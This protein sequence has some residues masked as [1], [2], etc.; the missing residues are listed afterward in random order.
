MGVIN[1]WVLSDFRK[2]FSRVKA[3]E[4][5]VVLV[6]G[7]M[8][9]VDVL[10]VTSVVRSPNLNPQTYEHLIHF[11]HSKAWAISDIQS[12]WANAVSV[13]APLI[14]VNDCI[15][16]IIDGVKQVKEAFYSPGTKKMPQ[17]SETQSKPRM[18][19]GQLWGIVSVLTGSCHLG[20]PLASAVPLSAELQDGLAATADWEGS[21]KNTNSH[22]FQLIQ[23]AARITDLMKKAAYV[24][25][26]T[27]FFT[28][29]NIRFLD[30]HN[31]IS[32]YPIHM[33]SKCKRNASVYLNPSP[34]P[35]GK[36]GAPAK[37]GNKV[38]LLNFFSSLPESQ[39][40]KKRM[41]LYGHR[42]PVQ[43]YSKILLWRSGMY[44]P[45]RFVF[46]RYDAVL[47][48][49]IMYRLRYPSA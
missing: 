6:I 27:Y 28:R 43:Y 30:A 11:F 15:I 2:C 12:T 37:K 49:L 10:G 25:A 13:V 44:R 7:F 22:P 38:T 16:L 5:F 9:R 35:P 14:T 17:D 8:I 24:L 32:D 29:I 21:S 39:L 18:I 45:V 33:I 3:Y 47:C 40:K 41:S 4:W 1:F 46:V 23:N 20:Q 26:D 31:A 36:R 42:K 34:K 19:H 48:T